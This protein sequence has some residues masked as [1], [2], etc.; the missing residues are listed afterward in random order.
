M[1]IMVLSWWLKSRK[2]GSKSSRSRL[3]S[4]KGRNRPALRLEALEDR[5]TPTTA[6]SF[7]NSVLTINVGAN[8]ETARLSESGGN[9][10]ISSNDAGGTTADAGAQTLGFS[11]TT[12]PNT[13]NTGSIASSED[14]RLIN[15]TGAAGSQTVNI[16]G[17]N[18]TALDIDDG[19]IENVSF[20]TAPST[21]ADISGNGTSDLTVLPTT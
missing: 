19:L 14:V 5:L 16:A 21:F 3:V 17:G 7:A 20:L 11:A 15:V 13:A 18:F 8:N 6:I 1:C 2:G 12:G 4:D 9:L 10:T